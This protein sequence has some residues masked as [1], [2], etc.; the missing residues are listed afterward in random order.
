MLHPYFFLVG[1]I[2][3]RASLYYITAMID[4]CQWRA[5]IRLCSCC[6]TASYQTRI[7]LWHKT[8]LSDG[9]KGHCMKWMWPFPAFFGFNHVPLL[10]TIQMI[11]LLS[12][13]IE[14]NPG[15]MTAKQGTYA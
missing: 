4:L 10:I 2:T 15:P 13:D 5:A 1:K 14:S 7:Q 11:I 8:D 6:F 9:N 12:G 3:T